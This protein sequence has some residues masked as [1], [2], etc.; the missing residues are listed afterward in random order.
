M[1][2][3][4]AK[5]G[6]GRIFTSN[7]VFAG[8]KPRIF[9]FRED[10][11]EVFGI[12][13]NEYRLADAF[14]T[15]TEGTKVKNIGLQFA[16]WGYGGENPY[17][18]FT[19]TGSSAEGFRF[20]EVDRN[21]QQQVFASIQEGLD[22]IGDKAIVNITLTGNSLFVSPETN[23]DT[24]RMAALSRTCGSGFVVTDDPKKLNGFTVGENQ[25]VVVDLAGHKMCGDATVFV[26]KGFLIIN[27]SVGTGCAFTTN[28]EPFIND[29]KH[30]SR[31]DETKDRVTT[32]T[33]RN[34]GSLIVNGGWFGTDRPTM[35]PAI[36]DVNWGNA[37]GMHGHS[38]TI[39]NGGCF[40]CASWHNNSAFIKGFAEDLG[41][42]S[43]YAN[44]TYD[45]TVFSY[46]PYSA[47]I[48]G[49]DEAHLMWNGGDVYGLYN[50]TFEIEGIGTTETDFGVVEINGGTFYNGFPGYT[51]VPKVSFG[52]QSMLQCSTPSNQYLPS[53]LPVPGDDNFEGYSVLTVNGGEFYD[54]IAVYT[55]TG[56][57]GRIT[58]PR[59]RTA[60]PDPAL[61][62]TGRVAIKGGT[63]NFSYS[64]E[65]ANYRQDYEF[66]PFPALELSE[67]QPSASVAALE[68]ENEPEL[69]FGPFAFIEGTDYGDA[70]EI[71]NSVV[72]HRYNHLF[73]YTSPT[74]AARAMAADDV[75][76]FVGTVKGDN[77]AKF[78]PE[79]C[80]AFARGSERIQS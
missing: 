28:F 67:S 51:L 58:P 63:F 42:D 4:D 68:N 23:A 39:V 70:F 71:A 48:E 14:F 35:S 21:E 60:Y 37:L 44:H 29:K 27:D 56:G 80:R 36:N 6:I 74:A 19:V 57:K 31:F 43:W 73:A 18:I 69:M 65:F 25:M 1:Q 32:E 11:A 13:S 2:I 46:A 7:P 75:P 66:R 34:E 20:S 78:F 47:V 17:R 33:I 79:L 9:N 49:Y 50:D 26:N 45:K 41:V 10:V 8:C 72:R 55:A 52:M 61:N 15:F 53:E 59:G 24:E 3:N 30:S 62:M 5:K 54:N 77:L 38:V 40:T 64:G 16:S 76:P 22:A 12:K